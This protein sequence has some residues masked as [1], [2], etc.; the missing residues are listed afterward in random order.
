VK[1]MNGELIG[2]HAGPVS[3][4]KWLDEKIVTTISTFLRDETKTVY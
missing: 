3:V 2:Q 4:L 1:E